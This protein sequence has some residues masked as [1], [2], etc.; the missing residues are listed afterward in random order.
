MFRSI[1]SFAGAVSALFV[2][3]GCAESVAA[4]PTATEV[5]N[6]CA[7]IPDAQART[8]LATLRNDVDAVEIIPETSTPKPFGFRPGGADIHV[9]AEPGWTAQWLAR[10]VECHGVTELAGTACTTSECPLG[11]ARVTTEVSATATGF[12]IALRSSDSDVAREVARRSG[13]VFQPQLVAAAAR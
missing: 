3:A 12:T 5:A 6:V 9:R 11:L 8:A 7:G 4:R 2:L 10:L 1:L 13:L